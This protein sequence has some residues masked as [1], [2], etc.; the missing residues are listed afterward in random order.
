M[1]RLGAYTV[2]IKDRAG[3]YIYYIIRLGTTSVIINGIAGHS[4]FSPYYR[5][6]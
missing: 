6:A 5:V 2:T 4:L 3:P 1:V